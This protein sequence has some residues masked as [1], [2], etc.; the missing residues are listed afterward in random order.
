MYV[1]YLK[2]IRGQCFYNYA[3][4]DILLL[5]YHLKPLG[6]IQIPCQRNRV[7][8]RFG[9]II[10]TCT[11]Q[12]LAH[13]LTHYRLVVSQRITVETVG[14]FVH[15]DIT[16]FSLSKPYCTNFLTILCIMTG[17]ALHE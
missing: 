6:L 13:L 15:G 14:W 10:I 11:F 4:H 17:R 12:N 2:K 1:G 3:I 9:I 8:C 5:N 7:M 16:L